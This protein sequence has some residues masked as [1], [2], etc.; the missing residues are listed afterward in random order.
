MKI[1]ISRFELNFSVSLPTDCVSIK[2]TIN[3]D[4][5]IATDLKAIQKIVQIKIILISY[6]YII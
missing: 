6:R 3:D 4:M 1:K 5:I 2:I